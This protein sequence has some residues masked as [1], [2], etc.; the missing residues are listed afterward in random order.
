MV[1]KPE[2]LCAAIAAARQRVPAGS[3]RIALSAQGELLTQRTR[4][5][6]GAAC[7]AWC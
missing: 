1:L 2:P 5:A 4:G 3:L 7:R 6:A